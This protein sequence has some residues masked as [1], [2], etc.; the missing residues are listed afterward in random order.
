[1]KSRVASESKENFNR[2]TIER[3]CTRED[4]STLGNNL[5]V[6]VVHLASL[7]SNNSQRMVELT[8][9]TRRINLLWCRTLFGEMANMTTV[10]A[11][12]ESYTQL[13]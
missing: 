5:H 8:L 3:K 10:V 9:R 7:G 2:V 12:V 6:G 11:G 13:L 4:M 1:M